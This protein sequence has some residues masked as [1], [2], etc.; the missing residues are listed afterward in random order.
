MLKITDDYDT[1]NNCTIN[2]NEDKIIIIRFV[3]FSIPAN[4]FILSQKGLV[5]NTMNKLLKTKKG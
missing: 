1:F 4:I 3:L 2:E 5:K